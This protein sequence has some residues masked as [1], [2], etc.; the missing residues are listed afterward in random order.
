MISAK[1]LE[2][3]NQ[4]SSDPTYA[5]T[6]F[7]IF[8]VPEESISGN[9]YVLARPNV[10][11]TLSSIHINKGI[12]MH[13]HEAEYSDAPMHLPAPKSFSNFT[14]ANG[15]SL[16]GSNAGRDYRFSYQGRDNLCNF[17]LNFKG[18]MDPYDALDPNH[19]PM[20]ETFSN[21]ED[22]TGAGD[23][24]SQGHYDLVG[25]IEG[26]LEL[27][28]KRYQVNCVDGLDRSWGPRLEWNAS[29]V[30]WMHMTFGKDLAFHLIM[31]LDIDNRTTRY[32]TFR[33]GYVAEKGEMIPVV[34][35][36]V[37]GEN[38]GMLG[39]H[40]HIKLRDNK[41]REWEMFGSALS[42]YPW[43]SAYSSFISYQSLYR[44]T[45]GERVGYSS[46]TDVVGLTTLGKHFS[47]LA[48]AGIAR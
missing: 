30:S 17:D 10:G 46:V 5:E 27:Y 33:F 39:M 22:A 16:Q 35:A 36:E 8:S 25:H 24:W 2:Y 3:H 44:W 45:M 32:T 13:A 37:V 21:T 1:D 26:E 6:Y 40:R 31:T 9:A 29:P 23:S 4:E 7:L 43:H 47:K 34:A 38:C 12:C 19:N 48:N 41:G 42:A 20:L 14:L 11:V 28:G 18:V 15:L